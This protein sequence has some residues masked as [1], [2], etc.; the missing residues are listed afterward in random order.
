MYMWR[1]GFQGSYRYMWRGGFQGSYR[2]MYVYK[3]KIAL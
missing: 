1:G 3:I 2:Y